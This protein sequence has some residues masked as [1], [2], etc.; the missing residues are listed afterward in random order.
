[1]W[2]TGASPVQ[3]ERSSAVA[4]GHGNSGFV[5]RRTQPS[6]ILSVSRRLQ[7]VSFPHAFRIP[8]R[9]I[10]F[11]RSFLFRSLGRPSPAALDVRR[12]RRFPQLRGRSH[13]RQRRRRAPRSSCLLL[14][15]RRLP[16]H[17]RLRPGLQT[18]FHRAPAHRRLRNECLGRLHPKP[19]HAFRRH[20][21]LSCHWQSR[22]HPAQNARRLSHP[23]C[24]LARHARAPAAAPPGR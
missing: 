11:L 6:T 7:T 8:F 24:R 4:C 18:A 16:R 19:T 17:L 10:R 15:S 2:G 5:D 21:R 13:A 22:T 1:M 20:S 12:L 14:A 3:A 9:C 23:I